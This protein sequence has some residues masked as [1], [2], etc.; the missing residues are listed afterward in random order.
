MNILFKSFHNINV[1]ENAIRTIPIWK[2]EPSGDY[3]S[4]DC[5]DVYQY[6]GGGGVL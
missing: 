5:G 6:V 3:W 4:S 2:C 1:P